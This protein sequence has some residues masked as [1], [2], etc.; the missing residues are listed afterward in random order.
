MATANSTQP[1]SN[2]I[3][4]PNRWKHNAYISSVEI[5]EQAHL[6]HAWVMRSI[7]NYYPDFLE[8]GGN[9]QHVRN[10]IV[11]NVAQAWLFVGT[12]RNTKH[13]T[14]LKMKVAHDFIAAQH[15]IEQ[16]LGYSIL[17]VMEG[18]KP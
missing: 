2:V 4:L 14:P 13:S 16:E 3:P 5:A 15:A 12:L 9:V 10:H 11:L 17:D 18:S 1:R 8:H 6:T 7:R